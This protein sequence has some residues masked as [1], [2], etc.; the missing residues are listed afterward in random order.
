MPLRADSAVEIA[1]TNG[2]VVPIAF[3]SDT[4][5]VNGTLPAWM[6]TLGW[7]FPLKHL[8]NLLGDAF[9]PYL[10]GNGFQLD[11]L[12]AIAAWGMAGALVAAW[13]LRRERDRTTGRVRIRQAGRL[14]H[15]DDVVRSHASPVERGLVHFDRGGVEFDRAHQ[16]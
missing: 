10:T 7:L 4:F 16:R 2:I 13:A 12:A 1:V 5:M 9:N 3:V 6:S 15:G 11:H 14:A 8:V